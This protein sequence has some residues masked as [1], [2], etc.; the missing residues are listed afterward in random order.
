MDRI[1]GQVPVIVLMDKETAGEHSQIRRWFEDSRF[2]TC[3]ASNVFEALEQ[4][5]DF[6]IQKR[7]DVVLIDV[8]CCEDELPIARDVAGLPVMT[9]SKNTRTKNAGTFY[10]A[11]LGAVVSKLNR[12]IPQ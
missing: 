8:D 2:S 6:T 1:N 9:L 10:P 4:L 7:P 11:N 3:E 5:S 12:L